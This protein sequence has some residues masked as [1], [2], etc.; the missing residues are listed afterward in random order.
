MRSHPSTRFGKEHS[1][2]R[3]NDPEFREL[4]GLGID[5]NRPAMLLDDNVV[6][7]RKAEAGSL[8][9]GLGRKEGIEHLVLHLGRNA[10]AVVADPDFDAVAKV[11]GRGS[12]RW[13]V[14]AP[15]RFALRVAA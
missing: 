8:A 11:S 7:D 9:S 15:I 5:L 13:L 2:T 10:G 14:V 12:K 3:Q 4:A 6:T 1:R